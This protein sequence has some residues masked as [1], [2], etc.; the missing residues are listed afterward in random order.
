M[1]KKMSTVILSLL[2]GIACAA[3]SPAPASGADGPWI[4]TITAEGDV[5]TVV[6]ESGSVWGGA[7]T[8][9]EEASIG[10]DVGAPEYM[11]A[12]PASVTAD[13]ERIL[14]RCSS[15]R[16]LRR[17]RSRSPRRSRPRWPRSTPGLPA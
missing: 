1:T 8:L 3:P 14:N 4:G 9:V 12:G 17:R 6:N 5:T 13:D 15:S 16:E 11:L 7:A 2:A 10:V